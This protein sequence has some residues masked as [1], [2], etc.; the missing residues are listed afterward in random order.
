[1]R[2]A[3]SLST[4]LVE[5]LPKE[6]AIAEAT[7]ASVLVLINLSANMTDVLRALM[8]EFKCF[9]FSKCLSWLDQY[10][11]LVIEACLKLNECYGWYLSILFQFEDKREIHNKH[12]EVKS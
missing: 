10:R 8:E 11:S 3:L 12:S 1:M 6:V 9:N 2:D 5:D 7:V 4:K